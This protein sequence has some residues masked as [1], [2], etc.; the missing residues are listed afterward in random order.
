MTTT[1]PMPDRT[2]LAALAGRFRV[3]RELGR[4][5]M[6][7]VYLAHDTMLGRDV[8]IKV[9]NAEVASLLGAE[10]F[11]RE[12]RLTARLVHPN[13]I[14]L[15]DSG[16]AVVDPAF[17]AA[18]GNT[19]PGAG[20]RP[21][22]FLYYVMPYIEGEPLRVRLRR[23]G[24]LAIEEVFRILT[25]IAEALG[26]A[27]AMGSVHRDVKPENIFWYR[28]R[29]LLSDFGVALWTGGPEA[30]R[31]TQ[32]GLV[33]GSPA[34]VSPEQ[35]D[36]SGVVD[37]RS[38]LYGL[39]CVA[40]ELL[41]G[42]PPYLAE[43][44]L[45][46]LAAHITRPIP[47]VR[48][49]RPDTPV[50]LDALIARLMAKHPD[51]RPANAAALLEEIRGIE[52]SISGASARSTVPARPTRTT[53]EIAGLPPDVAELHRKARQLFSSAVQ[54][55]QAAR[56]KY[57]M[58]RAYLERAMQQ[59]PTNA[60]LLNTLADLIHVAGVRG[61][62][63]HEE[64]FA[65]S[66]QLRHQALALD[67]NVGL[68]HSGLGVNL[69]YWMDEFDLAGE[70][71]RRGAE[72]SPDIADAHRYYGSWL[73]IA[74]RK[75]EALGEMRAAVRLAPNAAF[76]RV[77]EADVLMALGRY[78]EAVGS[79]RHALRLQPR[80]EAALERLEMSCHR[81]GRHEEALDARSALLGL[82]GETA[83]AAALA[84]RTE[85][86]GWLAAREHDLRA[87]VTSLLDRAAREDPFTDPNT[88]RQLADR[89][90][91]VLAELGEWREAM[92]W[93]ERAYH[94][95]P[96]RLRRVLMDLPYDHHGLAVDP[97]Y[98][99]LL[100]TAGLSELVAQ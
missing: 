60:L 52:G 47:A 29:A 69:L 50:L 14:P 24:T 53:E 72:L 42:R 22:A 35:A 77:G 46:L 34:Y 17:L 23:E 63:D 20:Q 70:E 19:P 8:A 33:V 98:A 51:D 45:A 41:A 67:D 87:E 31:M 86:E 76:M 18:G 13:I 90:I 55:G 56:E 27:H 36:G 16:E 82:R 58:A 100:R 32:A 78:E 91:I 61:F 85:R 95:R 73:K 38:D 30:G 44:P 26:Y 81:A 15:F 12:I 66:Q 37:G 3:A 96:G 43:T 5:G 74:G 88:S 57:S 10:R 75:E 71:L 2:L 4:G 79:L 49:S 83:R 6:G 40:Y 89:I 39:G 97:R 68:V 62:A 1:A 21:T 7:T 80:Y 99:R 9:L 65:R 64:S 92:D 54:G 93:V 48:D 11:A 28:G 59:V 25:D 84:E 94:R